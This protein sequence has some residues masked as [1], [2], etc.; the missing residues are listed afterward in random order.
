M[1]VLMDTDCLIK[2]TKAGLKEM[3]CRNFTIFVP[4]AVKHEALETADRHPDAE[5]IKKNI[6]AGLI[7][8]R[9]ESKQAAESGEDAI[10]DALSAGSY[11]TVCSDD[12][13]FIRRMR[14]MGVP[15]VTPAVF[16]PLLVERTV[17]TVEEA[18]ER[19]DT[20]S[21]FIS[22]EETHTVRLFLERW[23]VS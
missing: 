15:Y 21:S 11:E 22:D 5:V 4:P 13:K 16:L 20:L 14:V 12:K 17:L 2:L 8:V 19:L 7:N 23:G 6:L 1:V 18:Y 3:V 10:M 9:S